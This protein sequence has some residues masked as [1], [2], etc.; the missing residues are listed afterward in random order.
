MHRRRLNLCRSRDFRIYIR[1]LKKRE[2]VGGILRYA[3]SNGISELTSE[4]DTHLNVIRV[5]KPSMLFGIGGLIYVMIGL[6]WRGYGHWTMF[7]DDYLRYWFFN[8]ERPHY[9]SF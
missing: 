5:I 7:S 8:E 9:I 1:S 6:I 2:C 4:R 3:D